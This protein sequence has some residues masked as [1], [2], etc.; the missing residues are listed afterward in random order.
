[1]FAV[2]V[3]RVADSDLERQLAQRD[4]SL[5]DAQ[6]SIDRLLSFVQVRAG[7]LSAERLRHLVDDLVN[8]SVSAFPNAHTDSRIELEDDPETEAC[9]RVFIAVRLKTTPPVEAL[10]EGIQR[11]HRRLADS[12]SADERRAVRLIVEPE[13]PAPE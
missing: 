5:K 8:A 11:V 6:A 10:V 12:T 3:S 7:A 2:A 4:Q 9:H 13:L 1:M